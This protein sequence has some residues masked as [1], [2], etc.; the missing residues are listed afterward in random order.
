MA[1]K[2]IVTDKAPAPIGPYSQ[3]VRANGLIFTAGQIGVNPKTGELVAG[4]VEAETRQVM[5]NLQAVLEAAGS[6]LA[7]VVKATV[8]LADLNDFQ[9]MNEVYGRYVG[10]SRPA[11]STIQAARLPRNCRVEIDLIAL[12]G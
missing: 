3:A 10:E 4:G 12:A 8:Y 6:S 1:H 5:D 11:R 9:K 7:Q 2:T